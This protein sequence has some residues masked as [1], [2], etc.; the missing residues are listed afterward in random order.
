[1]ATVTEIAAVM[2]KRWLDR[3]KID[4]GIRQH[5]ARRDAECLKSRSS[6]G[7]W[8]IGTLYDWQEIAAN[9][10]ARTG[11]VCKVRNLR[12]EVE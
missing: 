10:Y 6:V 9:V 1:M 5:Y 8:G 11:K 4:P 7:R 3:Q 12:T 2:Q